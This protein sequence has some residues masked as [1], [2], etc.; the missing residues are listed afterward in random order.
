ML[1]TLRSCGAVTPLSLPKSLS[2][3]LLQQRDNFTLKPHVLF[4]FNNLQLMSEKHQRPYVI[5]FL[6][7]FVTGGEADCTGHP[8]GVFRV[9]GQPRMEV[10]K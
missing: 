9:C 8:D 4:N 1:S 6:C 3:A 5:S 10:P 2:V 7:W